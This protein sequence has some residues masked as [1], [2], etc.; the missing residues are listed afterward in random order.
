M[1]GF[2]ALELAR[3][4]FGF[5]ISFHIIFPAITIGL[6]S[7][8]AVLEGLWLWWKDAVYR[9]LYHFWSKIFAVNFAMG[10]VSGLVMAYQFGTNWSYFSATAGS[11]TGPLLTYEV[12]TAFFLE[13]GF[14]GVMLFGWNKVGPGL[15][16]FATLMVALGTLISATWILASNSWMQTPQGFQ[17]IDGRIVPVDWLKVIFNP[18][19]PYRLA[20]MTIAA[21][22]ATALFVGASAAWHL[23]RGNTT[24][25]IRTMFSMAMW[26]VFIVAPVQVLVG[27]AHGLNT[28][29]HQPAKIAALEGHWQNE[30]GE[31]LPLILFGV[32]DMAAEKTRYAIEIP[33]LGGLVLTHDIN[34]RIPSLK[35]F[36]PE[37]RPN[38][39]IIFWTFRLMVGLGMLMVFLG[40]W[41]LYLRARGGLF[42]SRLFLRFAALMGPGGLLAI[43]AGWLTTEIGRQP[44]IV[45]GVMRTRDAVSNHSALALSTTLVVFVV[46]YFAVFGTGVS[47]M[48]KLVAKGPDTYVDHGSPQEEGQS[49]RPARP[50]SAAPD[51]IEPAVAVAEHT[52]A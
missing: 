42:E 36:A 12:L 30:P 8:L 45:Y 1:F 4:Q 7:Y 26:M 41:S 18:S 32:P 2:T 19:F 44:W 17:M 31:S 6:A 5:T 14:L 15:H 34:G 33:Y 28:L 46:M 39:T 47:Y 23:L 10:V 21:Y 51:H 16:F 9:D 52:E 13:A 48:L 50:L 24:P 37:D 25:A 35:E 27:D 11:I 20:H 40:F 29:Q 3:I 43:L 38:S 49:P 22:L